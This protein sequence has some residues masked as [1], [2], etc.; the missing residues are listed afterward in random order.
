MACQA[1]RAKV[2]KYFRVKVTYLI[3]ITIFEGIIPNPLEDLRGF[4]VR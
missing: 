4:I 1:L 2:Y 3:S